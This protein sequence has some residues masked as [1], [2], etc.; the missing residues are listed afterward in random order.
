ML[1]RLCTLPL[2]KSPDG[3]PTIAGAKNKFKPLGGETGQYATAVALLN[4]RGIDP[5]MLRLGMVGT[6]TVISD[7]AGPIEFLAYL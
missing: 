4:D 6:A 3:C 2:Q 7:K 5:D 1:C